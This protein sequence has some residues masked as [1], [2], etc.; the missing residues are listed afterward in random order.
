MLTFE[1]YS[2]T[3]VVTTKSLNYK[4]SHKMKPRV[5]TDYFEKRDKLRKLN[6]IYDTWNMR[7]LCGTGS[8]MRVAKEK[9]NYK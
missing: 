2:P 3:N 1:E 7:S 8:L 9:P 6:M 4:H 5:W